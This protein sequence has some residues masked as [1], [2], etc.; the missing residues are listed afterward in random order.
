MRSIQKNIT[1]DHLYLWTEYLKASHES[2]VCLLISGA[3]ASAMFWSEDFCK[4]L[5]QAGYS[6][7]RFDH[8]DQGLS[9]AVNWDE[10]PYTVEDLAKDA[11]HILD[12][13]GIEKAHVIGH[14]MGGIIAQW[15]AIQYPHRLL[16]YVSMSV[17]TCGLLGKPSEKVMEILME[18]KPSQNFEKDFPGF[19]RSWEVLNGDYAVDPEKALPYT[20]DLY[21]RSNHLVGVAWHHIWCQENYQDLSQAIKKITIPGLFLHGE[22]DPLI[23][24]EGGRKTQALV[25]HSQFLSISGMGH[26]FFNKVLEKQIVGYL[27]DFFEGV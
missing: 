9:D 7:I 22:K 18:N 14:S 13:Y 4:Y 25:P 15:L 8:R 20:K 6:V 26:M 16:S 3:G 11:M 23:P 21:L 17:S 19:M 27:L 2:A 24:I 5:L 10:K 12:E 1:I